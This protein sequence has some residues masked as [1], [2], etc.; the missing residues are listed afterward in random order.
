MS[1]TIIREGQARIVSWWDQ[2]VG[3]LKGQF[4]IPSNFSN[5]AIEEIDRSTDEILSLDKYS[6]F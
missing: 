5:Q 4:G 1:Q 6:G 3:S 2:Y